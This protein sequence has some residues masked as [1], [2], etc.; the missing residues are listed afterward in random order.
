MQHWHLYIQGRSYIYDFE[1][2]VVDN[3]GLCQK[4]I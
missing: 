1:T 2:R 4:V 3:Y